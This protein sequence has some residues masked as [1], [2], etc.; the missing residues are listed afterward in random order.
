MVVMPPAALLPKDGKSGPLPQK[1]LLIDTGLTPDEVNKL[2][3][4]GDVISFATEP[5][6]LC[7]ESISGHTLDNRARKSVV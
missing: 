3:R 6:E 4:V 1:Y 2:V 5:L 7:S